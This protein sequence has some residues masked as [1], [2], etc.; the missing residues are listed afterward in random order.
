[1]LFMYKFLVVIMVL[2]GVSEQVSSEILKE[3]LFANPLL[4]SAKISPDGRAIAYVGADDEGISNVFIG[5]MGDR[6]QITFFKT[7]EIIQF[8]WSGDS[9]RI[10]LLKD[11]NGTGK[12]LLHGIHIHSKEHVVY[13]EKFSNVNAKMVQISSNKNSAVIGLNPRNPHYHDLYVVDLDSGKLD[14]LFENDH[15]AKFLVSDQ[16]E[17]I[18]KMRIDDDGSWTVL[19]ADNDVFLELN[20]SEAFQTEFLSYDEK[21]QCVYLLDN[22]FSDK[23]QLM[24]KSLEGIREETM[25]GAASDSD[26]DDVLLIAGEPKAYASYYVQKQ[27]H[28]IDPSIATDIAFLEEKMGPNFDVLSTS[29]EGSFWI[30]SDRH[31]DK[32]GQFWIY[33]RRAQD[34]SSL[35]APESNPSLRFSK[36]YPLIAEARDG[37]K[38]VCYYTLPKEFDKGGA[39]DAPI[40]LVVVPHGGPF[41]VRD[42]FEFNSLHQWL[43]SCGYAVLSVNFRLSSGFGKAFVNAGNGQWGGKA[44]E[45]VIDAVES[46]IAKGIAERGKLAVFGASY[47]GYEALASLTFSPEYFTCC[48]SI[49][50]PSNLKTVLDNVPQFWEFT[51]RPLSDKM[52]FFT[53]KAFVT[54]MGGNPNDPEGA[55]YLEK[56]SPLNALEAIKA[57]LLLIHGRNDHIVAEKESEQIYHSMKNNCKTVTYVLFTDEGHRIAKFANKMMYLNH[58][59]QFLSQ[60]LGGKYRPVDPHILANSSAQILQ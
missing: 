12:L 36:M 24:A 8:F 47:G 14:L 41:K 20:P 15:Y 5:S 39:V 58:A 21:K 55:R 59:E 50:G 18:L 54:S 27:W 3:Q 57:P 11:E 37:Q 13:T 49:C 22:R 2:M 51:N 29:R 43:A 56:C 26:I 53:K 7:P 25:L 32:G 34:L 31:A 19:T 28:A 44:H 42:T 9:Q 52:N 40:P 48:V 23:N 6:V 4:I 30:V 60:H 17:L 38:L 46:C 1:M 16:L 33:D 10:L 35:T 45:D